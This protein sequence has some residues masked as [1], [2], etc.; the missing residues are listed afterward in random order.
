MPEERIPHARASNFRFATGWGDGIMSFMNR[1]RLCDTVFRSLSMILASVTILLFTVPASGVSIEE[2][3]QQSLYRLHQAQQ[4]KNRDEAAESL[5]RNMMVGGYYRLPGLGLMLQS[6][7]G[8]PS[9]IEDYPA[10]LSLVPDEVKGSF[11]SVDQLLVNGHPRAAAGQLLF[12]WNTVKGDP[13]NIVSGLFMVMNKLY[14]TAMVFLF[15]CGLL[16][17]MKYGR[18]VVHDIR[19]FMDGRFGNRYLTL[20][21]VVLVAILPVVFTL[22]VRYLPFYWVLL[23]FP[24]SAVRERVGLVLAVVFAMLFSVGAAYLGA[25]GSQTGSKSFLYY[26]SMQAPFSMVEG[27]NPEPQLELFAKATNRLRRGRYTDA[28]NFYKEISSSS[29]L[30]PYALN[31]I[32]VSYYN[33]REFELARDFIQEAI[34]KGPD[35]EWSRYNLSAV[36]LTT[37]NLAESEAELSNGF[38]EHPDSTLSAVLSQ[39]RNSVPV[40]MV[41]DTGVLYHDLFLLRFDNGWSFST[42]T[43][44]REFI[45]LMV[46]LL[47]MAALYSAFK[48][49][50]L[51][52]SCSRCGNP[53]R[54]LE[55]H[56]ESMCKQCVTVYVKKDNLDSSRRMAKVQSIRKYNRI[57]DAIQKTIGIVIPGSHLM[58]VQQRPFYGVILWMMGIGGLAVGMEGMQKT[59]SWVVVLPL[60]ILGGAAIVVNILS[61]FSHEQEEE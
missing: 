14:A 7:E 48:D 55:S 54:F 4:E 37:Y 42:M 16:M 27:F 12:G 53:Y 35:L 1:L 46:F 56:H 41:P 13:F 40:V 8:V 5:R 3:V 44:K 22:H 49:R 18:N 20:S 57:R 25:V 60:L 36:L 39:V 11:D 33:L 45:F 10:L 38:M 15:I 47:I 26:S 61:V 30:Y 58:F 34:A 29:R 24:Y 21:V 31:N 50:D 23:L 2:Q 43:G 6:G 19:T 59:G 17:M 32:G 51:S 52:A 28:I 9:R